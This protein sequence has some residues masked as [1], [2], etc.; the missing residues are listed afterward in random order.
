VVVE[1]AMVE[2]LAEVFREAG[3]FTDES[4]GHINEEG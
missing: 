1:Q 4:A 3:N 2:L